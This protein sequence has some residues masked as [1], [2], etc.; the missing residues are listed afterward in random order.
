MQNSIGNPASV[1][2]V[3][4]SRSFTYACAILDFASAT[5][6]KIPPQYHSSLLFKTSKDTS[7]TLAVPV[8][9]FGRY[10]SLAKEVIEAMKPE[11]DG[12]HLFQ[13]RRIRY[14]G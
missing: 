11:Y 3:L 12:E 1:P 7:M 13:P 6:T 9:L 10:S 5:S 8:V 14:K 2:A 4:L